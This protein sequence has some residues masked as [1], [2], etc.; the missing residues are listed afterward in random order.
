MDGRPIA[1]VVKGLSKYLGAG[2]QETALRMATMY[3]GLRPA[4]ALPPGTGTANL[5]IRRGTSSIIE[6][7][8]VRWYGSGILDEDM[9]PKE[10]AVEGEWGA[11]SADYEKLS[12]DDTFADLPKMEQGFRCQGVTRTAIPKDAVR[13]MSSPFVAY[14]HPTP[15]GNIGYLRVPHY[16]W[17][18][19]ADL[20]FKQYEYAVSEL[21]KKTVGLIIDQDHN[22]GGSVSFL[23]KFV[24]LFT[25]K[26]YKGLEFQF[27]ATRAEYLTFKHWVDADSRLTL[28]GSDLVGVIDLVKSAW[29]NGSRMSPKTTFRNNQMIQPNRIHYTK[30]IIVLIDEMSG[31][32]GDAFPAMMQGLGKLTLGTRTMG[33]GGHVTAMPNLDISA[34]KVNITKSLFFRPDG[35]PVENNGAVANI[36]YQPTR[37]DFLYEYRNYQK[38]YLE[39]LAKLIP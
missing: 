14:Y 19:D 20:R 9:P 3:L 15:K 25:D 4:A 24:G 16:S 32:G 31:S 21:E 13:L 37:D 2:Y 27:L 30:P 26:P 12:I 33:A 5:K 11:V 6:P 38:R 23:E 8:T 28:E 10:L 35:E 22:C 7:V 39:E 1:S 29:Q 17:G 36:A 34:N 18:T